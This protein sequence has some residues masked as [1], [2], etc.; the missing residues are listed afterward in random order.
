MTL[1]FECEGQVISFELEFRKRKTLQIRV[2]PEKV[3]VI[4]PRSLSKA[5]VIEI[6]SKKGKWIVNKRANY[7]NFEVA[8]IE[9]ELIDGQLFMFLGGSYSLKITDNIDI[10]KPMIYIRGGNIFIET[11]WR[12]DSK[13]RD[14]L[15]IWY[16]EKAK[17]TISDRVASFEERFDKKPKA[18]RI[19]DPKKRWGSCTGKDELLFNWRCV[20]IS[21]PL[22]DYIVVHEMCH[23]VEKN[24]GKGFWYLVEV[25]LPDFKER[26]KE[27]RNVRIE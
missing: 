4:A 13:L 8:T 10:K 11:P 6:V 18:I 1:E 23:M 7:I 12:D 20:M 24:H 9:K 5:R 19:K 15:K 17:E 27:L 14:A 16:K 26:K 22:L 2:E 3:S 21:P 25:M